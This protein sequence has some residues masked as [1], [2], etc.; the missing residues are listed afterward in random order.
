MARAASGN[1]RSTIAITWEEF[2]YSKGTKKSKLPPPQSA[3]MKHDIKD[4][5]G[6]DRVIICALV[7]G[8]KKNHLKKKKKYLERAHPL[9][10]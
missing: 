2:K 4:H 1:C 5:Q 3:K 6:K 7:E 9:A 10:A 8:R